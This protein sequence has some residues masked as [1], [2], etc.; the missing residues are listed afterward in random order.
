MASDR[1]GFITG[2]VRGKQKLKR[3]L[4]G[5]LRLLPAHK[6]LDK[7]EKLYRKRGFQRRAEEN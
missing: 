2:S 7:F 3:N 5:Y 6:R 1:T 4:R